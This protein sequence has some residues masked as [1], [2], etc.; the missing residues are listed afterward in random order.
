MGRKVALRGQ[1]FI[2]KVDFGQKSRPNQQR[3]LTLGRGGGHEACVRNLTG[4]RLNTAT[5]V[6]PKTKSVAFPDVDCEATIAV[7]PP[8]LTNRR[9]MPAEPSTGTVANRED[10]A[11]SEVVNPSAMA[12]RNGDFLS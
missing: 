2:K 9:F 8:L 12:A 5:Y 6:V 1:K 7:E 4:I 10:M 3:H 11:R